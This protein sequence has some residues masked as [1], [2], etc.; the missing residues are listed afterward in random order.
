MAAASL[1]PASFYTSFRDGGSAMG[2]NIAAMLG[3]AATLTDMLAAQVHALAKLGN[4]PDVCVLSV[5]MVF[6]FH[7]LVSSGW[8]NGR[9]RP[10]GINDSKDALCS[11]LSVANYSAPRLSAAV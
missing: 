2:W 8:L 9:L 5:G 10:T 4:A 6:F 1:V 11:C 7:P 3:G